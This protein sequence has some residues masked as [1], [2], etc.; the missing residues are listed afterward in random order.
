MSGCVFDVQR[1][2]THDGPG[3]RTVLFFKGCSLRCAWCENPESQSFDPELLHNP[4]RC[5]GCGSCL[6][7]IFGGIMQRDESGRV[8]VAHRGAESRGAG[9]GREPSS[10]LAATCP[11]LALRIAGRRVET[12]DIL[13]ELMN[14][15][16]FFRGSGGGVTLS[17]GEPLAQADFALEV[18]TALVGRG[19]G[20]AVESCLAVSRPAVEAMAALP[21]IWLVDLKHVDAAVFRAGTGG[22]LERVLANLEYLAESGANLNLRVPVVPGFNADDDSL[23]VILDYAASLPGGGSDS[24]SGRASGG[25]GRRL[26]LLPY[27][28]LAMGK[29]AQLGRSYPYPRGLAVDKAVLRRAAERGAALGL[30]MTIGG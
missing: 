29:Y 30:D 25:R 20:V 3:I 28:E 22:A 18:A 8:E 19:I 9:R 21:I 17:G 15:E 23:R 10:A 24:L 16:A 14:D 26:D 7:P 11:A 1:F 5:V 13:A 6:D 12:G 27:H 4:A 2:S